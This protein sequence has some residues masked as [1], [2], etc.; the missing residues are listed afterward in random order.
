MVL[1]SMIIEASA[2][3]PSSLMA[4]SL[5]LDSRPGMCNNSE[6]IMIETS[7]RLARS[8]CS[9][10]NIFKLEWASR[11]FAIEAAPGGPMALPH[12]LSK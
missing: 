7:D 9:Y 12:R 4:F 11:L 8:R 5:S 3:A 1:L 2:S 10:R 6:L